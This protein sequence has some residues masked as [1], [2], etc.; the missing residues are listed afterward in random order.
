[1]ALAGSQSIHYYFKLST[2]ATSLQR[3]R[4]L[5][6][7]SNAKV[8][9]RQQSVNQQLMNGVYKTLIFKGWRSRRLM[10]ARDILLEKRPLRNLRR[11]YVA[12]DLSLGGRKM[13]SGS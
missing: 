5:K 9:S 2:R 6:R 10:L 1:M 7:V 11:A 12:H 4:S 3:Q 13:H 8:T